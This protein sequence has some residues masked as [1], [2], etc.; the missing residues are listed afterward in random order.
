MSL[1]GQGEGENRQGTPPQPA[2]DGSSGHHETPVGALSLS[3]GDLAGIASIVD[4][5]MRNAPAQAAAQDRGQ[6]HQ[7]GSSRIEIRQKT[8]VRPWTGNFSKGESVEIALRVFK[9][10]VFAWL[11]SEGLDGFMDSQMEIPVGV[12]NINMQQLRLDYG[13]DNVTKSLKVWNMLIQKICCQ[14]IQQQVL[15]CRTPQQAW[16]V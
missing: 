10:S 16:R 12:E 15:A 4:Q 11:N 5:V 1:P 14:P 6:P 7:S 2:A 9:G 13:S 8:D 3:P